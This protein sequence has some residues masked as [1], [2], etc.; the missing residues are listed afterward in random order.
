MEK[1]AYGLSFLTVLYIIFLYLT[2]KTLLKDTLYKDS[3]SATKKKSKDK[4]RPNKF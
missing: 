4:N 3:F 1:L 2:A